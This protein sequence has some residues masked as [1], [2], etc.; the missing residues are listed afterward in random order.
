MKTSSFIKIEF[1]DASLERDT[2]PM[3]KMSPYVKVRN[4]IQNFE[5]KTKEDKAAHKS[6]KFNQQMNI[7]ISSIEDEI[8]IDVIDKDMFSDDIVGSIKI[9]PFEIIES[10]HRK[11]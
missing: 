10:F 1:I 4:Q 8:E 9:K 7:P 2:E 3:G 11:L 5:R 6:P